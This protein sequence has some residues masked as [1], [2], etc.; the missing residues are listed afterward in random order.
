MNR[1]KKTAFTLIELLV[2]VAIIAVL[3]ALLLPALT[4]A[5]KNAR[6]VVC[7][8]RQRDLGVGIHLYADT[9]WDWLPPAFNFSDSSGGKQP[10]WDGCWYGEVAKMLGFH[11]RWSYQAGLK[12]FT[13]CSEHSK[14][15]MGTASTSFMY[16]V[17]IH[18]G[19]SADPTNPIGKRGREREDLR[20]IIHCEWPFLSYILSPYCDWMGTPPWERWYEMLSR[21]HN[22]GA[23]FLFVAGNVR[24][25]EDRGSGLEY[26]DGQ[27]A[28]VNWW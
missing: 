18:N 1:N 3:V 22:N 26:R 24:W 20:V 11:D 4:R 12:D 27:S 21:E 7:Q 23:N 15:S 13:F 10:Y 5:R 28:D 17:Q 6:T 9:W 2:V 25:I 14:D 8:A 16:S 19:L